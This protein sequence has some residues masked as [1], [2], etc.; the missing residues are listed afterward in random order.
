MAVIPAAGHI[1]R[2]SYHPAHDRPGIPMDVGD[3]RLAPGESRVG[4]GANQGN[5]PGRQ[6]ASSG[7]MELR[8]D[9]QRHLIEDQCGRWSVQE[10]GVETLME[11]KNVATAAA[12]A[13]QASAVDSRNSAA[14]KASGQ[15]SHGWKRFSRRSPSATWCLSARIASTIDASLSSSG[16]SRTKLRSI[17]SRSIGNCFSVDSDE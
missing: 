1:V 16:R 9:E 14:T 11:A 10:E 13:G 6:N 12:A 15:S 2:P 8:C 4:I 17:L 3:R 7:Q 5:I